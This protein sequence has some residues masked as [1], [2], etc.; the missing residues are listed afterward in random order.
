M[1][2]TPLQLPS[3]F[4]KSDTYVRINKNLLGHI[5][6]LLMATTYIKESEIMESIRSDNNLSYHPSLVFETYMCIC[7]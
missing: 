1:N 4:K 6:K 7:V 5:I 2:C 3:Y